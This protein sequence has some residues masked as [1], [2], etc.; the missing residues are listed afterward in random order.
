MNKGLVS[1]AARAMNAA[2]KTRG[3]GRPRSG[4]KRCPCGAMTAKRAKARA[5]KCSGD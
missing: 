4:A 1:E 5:H 2:R 3:G